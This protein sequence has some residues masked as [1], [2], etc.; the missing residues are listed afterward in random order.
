M[1][2]RSHHCRRPLGSPVDALLY[3]MRELSP[4][5][6]L[7]NKHFSLMNFDDCSSLESGILHPLTNE[8]S[9]KKSEIS[10]ARKGHRSGSLSPLIHL[11]FQ[12]ASFRGILLFCRLG[13]IVLSVFPLRL[14]ASA[15]RPDTPFVEQAPILFV[16]LR[17]IPP[18]CS[19]SASWGYLL[20]VASGKNGD[21]SSKS[22]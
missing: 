2:V 3:W 13:S 6:L 4:A 16:S 1:I 18:K 11:L 17:F 5:T 14:C 21:L 19:S 12:F 8:C 9:G 20:G 15:L 10:A 7:I 22:D